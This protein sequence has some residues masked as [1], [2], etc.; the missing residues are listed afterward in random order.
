MASL[1][2]GELRNVYNGILKT[3]DNAAVTASEKQVTDGEGN[4]TGLKLT[5]TKAI[6]NL[7][8]VENAAVDTSE[9]TVLVI[10]PSGDVKSRELPETNFSG[11]NV[12]VARASADV[13]PLVFR[14]IDNPT[15]GDSVLVGSSLSLI[16]G[17][18]AVVVANSGDLIEINA[19]I[20]FTPSGGTDDIS[21]ALVIQST[22]I[23]EIR[24]VVT[25]ATGNKEI[26][27]HEFWTAQVNDTEIQVTITK[28]VGTPTILGR[29]FLRVEKVG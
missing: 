20:Y 22:T 25:T 15:T 23:R 28:N 11:T 1:D 21:V 5:S 29:S 26:N 8:K 24:E 12:I 9:N 27:I 2:A 7:L 18:N 16:A 4:N 10:D 17:N 13:S 6:A 3:T 19:S 14:N